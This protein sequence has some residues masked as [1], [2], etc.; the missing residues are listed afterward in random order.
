MPRS[1][2]LEDQKE[3]RNFFRYS[4]KRQQSSWILKP[5]SGEGGDGI[6]IHSNL[7]F[8]SKE[9][10]TCSNKRKFIVQEY[11]SNLLLL[12]NRKFDIR[13]YMLIAKTSPHYLVFYHEGQL[14]L[15]LTFTAIEMFTSP[16]PMYRHQWKDTQQMTTF[17]HFKN[18]KGILMSIDLKMEGIL[19]QIHLFHL[20]RKLAS[21]LHT[22][23][24][25]VCI[26]VVD[27]YSNRSN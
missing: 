22:Q 5:V 17:G 10:A 7:T 15:S 6:T 20:Y 27:I 13:A 26:C 19:S 2:I 9:Y 12:N 8:F 21:S 4:R 14:R 23:V 16:I 18:Y 25:Y 24:C 11:I 3:C 1:F